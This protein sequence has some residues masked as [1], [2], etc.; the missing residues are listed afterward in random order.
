[1]WRNGHRIRVGAAGLVF[2]CLGAVPALAGNSIEAAC[3]V[4]GGPTDRGAFCSCMQTVANMSLTQTDQRLAAFIL[5][6]PGRAGRMMKTVGA[7]QDFWDRFD[8]FASATRTHCVGDGKPGRQENR[9]ERLR[10]K[11]AQVN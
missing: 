7:R 8:V 1:M 5:R 4:N 10:G 3:R 2:L 6:D 11:K 9:K